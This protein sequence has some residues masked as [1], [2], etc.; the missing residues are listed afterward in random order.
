M[1]GY[2]AFA[3]SI[4]SGR[5]FLTILGLAAPVFMTMMSKVVFKDFTN[6]LLYIE[7]AIDF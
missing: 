2:N 5:E 6:S 4:P 1:K 7:Y 3:L